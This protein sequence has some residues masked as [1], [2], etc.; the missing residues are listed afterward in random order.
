MARYRI[1]KVCDG[2]WSL[3]DHSDDLMMVVTICTS[4][5]QALAVMFSL[6]RRAAR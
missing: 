1:R 5:E 2:F 3:H 6:A 4:W